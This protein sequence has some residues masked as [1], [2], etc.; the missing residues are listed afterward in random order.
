MG[1]GEPRRYFTPIVFDRESIETIILESTQRGSLGGGVI[2]SLTRRVVISTLISRTTLSQ[3]PACNPVGIIEG[4]RHRC[5]HPRHHVNLVFNMQSRL[6]LE[7]IGLLLLISFGSV[8][9]AED[10]FI[11]Y[12]ATEDIVYGHK[13]G[14]ALTL[15]V[16]EPNTDPNGLG[17][18]LVSSGSWIS[19]KSDN[20]EEEIGRASCRERV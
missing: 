2:H 4:S 6:R 13:D 18:I 17:L 19:R 11:P 7:M 15:D 20:F 9:Q 3:Q 14:M 10:A 1:E 12:R 16:I 5:G 8:A